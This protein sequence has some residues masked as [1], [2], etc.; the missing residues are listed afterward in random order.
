MKRDEPRVQ[1]QVGTYAGIP[2]IANDSIPTSMGMVAISVQRGPAMIRCPPGR[3]Y[4]A[5]GSIGWDC[6]CGQRLHLD[7]RGVERPLA[8]RASCRCGRAYLAR[9][10]TSWAER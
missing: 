3:T 7:L 6:E 4:V 1:R 5:E 10:S 8:A 9:D 2:V